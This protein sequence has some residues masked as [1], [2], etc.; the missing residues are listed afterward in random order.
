[1]Y[2]DESRLNKRKESLPN[3]EKEYCI[4][5]MK[6]EGKNVIY[7]IFDTTHHDSGRKGKR[8]EKM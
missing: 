7:H 3:E 6:K 5:S 2:K 4:Y 8:K 1:V